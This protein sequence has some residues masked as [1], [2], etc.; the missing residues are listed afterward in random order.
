MAMTEAQVELA[1][2][3]V[4]RSVGYSLRTGSDIDDAGERATL[5][6]THSVT[7]LRSAIG[8]LN[9]QLTKSSIDSIIA[10]LS[11]PPHLTLLENNRWFH[12]LLTDG[13]PVEYK[14]AKT[15]EM[16]G[17]RARVID[18][19]NPANN[20]FLVV[21]QL[22]IQGPSG[23][24]IRTDLILYVNGLPLVVIELKDPADRAATL[25]M[26]IDQLGRYKEIA[27]D[28]FVPNL[29]LVVSDGLLTRVGSITSGRQRFTPW[30]PE[31]GGEPTLE[32]LI[33]ELLNPAALLDYLQSCVAFEEDE[34]GNIVKKVAGYHQ[35]R[36]VRKARRQ[37]I[38]AQ[39][40]PPLP[41]GEGRGEGAATS[42]TLLPADILQY[43][44]E[45]RHNQTDAEKLLWSILRNR[46]LG[47]FKFRRQHPL[48]RHILDFYC[49]EAKL[50]IE[51]DGGQHNTDEG[52]RHD[53][54]RTLAIANQGIQE[55]RFWNHE[56][57]QETEAVLEVI[58]NALQEQI[59][60][61]PQK[62]PH[63]G[64]LP[65]GSLFHTSEQNC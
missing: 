15:G 29:L 36:A 62:H 32:A 63:P 23:K 24:T 6:L 57:L 54:K 41:L 7:R 38:A 17:G 43:A 61:H 64:P 18:F 30:R 20:D 4:L 34:R 26:A 45:L 25:D 51:L 8:G 60:R 58:W 50:S 22:T 46:R 48:G 21:R 35:F 52:R 9:P 1:A 65:E 10:S 5:G 55:L 19:E 14:D 42:P 33:R 40:F 28:L 11:R 3:S 49:H 16:R 12:G 39:V 31:R 13:V 53:E 59:A 2:M 44:R 27:P 37:V 47:D 56:V